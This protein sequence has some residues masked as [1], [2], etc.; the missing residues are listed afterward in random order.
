MKKINFLVFL[1]VLF[2]LSCEDAT[3]I[4][5]DGEVND[6]ETFTS[7]AQMKLYLSEAYDK[8]S[9]GGNANEIA[10][11]SILTD[12][13]GIGDRGTPTDLYRFNVAIN[14]DY[15]SQI[16]LDNY[17]TINYCNRI[18]R[19]AALVTPV[20][21]AD[22]LVYKDILAQA[23]ALRAY[24]HFQLLTY[25]STDLK[26]D[27]ALGVILMDRVPLTNEAL[28]R[29]TN[30][31]VFA[32]IVSD[33]I[34]AETN[35]QPLPPGTSKPW[36]FVSK[37]M[38][39]ALRARMYAYRGDYAQAEGFADTVINNSGIVLA[40]GTVAAGFYNTIS[41][42]AYKRM[43]QDLSQ[44]EI[45]WSIGRNGGKQAM[46]T[47][48]NVN[49]SFF[50]SALFDMNRNLF[51]IL[52]NGGGMNTW[53]IRRFVNIDP[54]A[55][56]DPSYTSSTTYNSSDVLVIDKYP[57]IAGAPLVNDIKAFRLSEMLL[58]KAE[59]RAANADWNGV[60][61]ILKSIRDK[62][63]FRATP[64]PMP[65]YANPQEAWADILLERRVELCFEGHRWIDLK[66]LGVNAN[67][68]IDR[69][70]RD[71]SAYLLSTC[72][73]PTTDYRFTLPIPLNEL[74]ANPTI[75]QNP[76]Y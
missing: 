64:R 53:D 22:E 73:I 27:N 30:G 45:I 3:N 49:G 6:A 60:A 72:S 12:E 67:V 14:N 29:N 62:R 47:I 48:Y 58:I 8:L 66:R 15:S 37:N 18:I 59:A 76:G 21:S 74:S 4:L 35:L 75:Q 13:V 61:A 1:M 44:G 9:A 70:I 52:E 57:G 28:P 39:N 19:G 55:T 65:S 7:T 10:L 33:L 56:I 32:L 54:T 68:T 40:D 69:Y 16:W 2:L 46:V 38:V 63:N 41:A 51:N 23:R 20:D 34:Y 26:N 24:C 43:F 71:C 31:Q 36:T 5:Q 17:T 11:T 42:N 50:G 25:F